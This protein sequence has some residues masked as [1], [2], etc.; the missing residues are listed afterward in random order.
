MLKQYFQTKLALGSDVTLFIVGDQTEAVVA[1]LFTSLWQT[2]YRFERQFSRFIPMSELSTFNR[3]AG[4]KIVITP[5]FRAILLVAKNLGVQTDGLYNPFILPALQRAGYT[6][7]FVEAYAADRQD[8][9]SKRAV[10]P[11]DHLQI[12][13]NWAVIPYGTAI[14]LGGCGK[15][16]LADQLADNDVPAWVAGY[17]FSIGG[18]VV[19][20]GVDILGQP[21]NIA[22]QGAHETAASNWQVQ[23]TGA[24][25]AAATSGTMI[26][27]GTSGGRDW[28]HLI[29][30]RT[31]QPAVSDTSMATVYTVSA[32]QADV[33]AS[34]AIILGSHEAV[35]FLKKHSVVAACLQG[36]DATGKAINKKFGR[37]LR[38]VGGRSGRSSSRV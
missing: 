19:G 16:Y 34:C 29:D 2:I 7:S 17:W 3:A 35:T 11:V 14:D 4:V 27:Q 9:F 1:E 38:P 36:T 20:A 26:R 24:R 6:R 28:H 10:V 31:L 33:L 15:G 8:D 32:V 18:D 13:D 5:E 30:P 25:F 22:I 12:G 21:W 37:A 23:T